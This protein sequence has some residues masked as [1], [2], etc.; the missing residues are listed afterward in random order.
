M[1]SVSSIGLRRTAAAAITGLLTV[2]ISAALPL[3][4]ALADGA[5][6]AVN[7]PAAPANG[8]QTVTFTTAD[9]FAPSPFN[10]TVTI[11]RSATRGDSSPE[12]IDADSTDA[13]GNTVTATFDLTGANP[14]A[15]DVAIEGA[16][17]SPPSPDTVD[18]CQSCLTVQAGTPTI[19]SVQP[20]ATGADFDYP[21]WTI[22]GTNFT[23][24]PYTQCSALP[25]GSKTPNVAI[26]NGNALD[27]DV[28]LS[29]S[30]SD[31]S[32]AT[33]LT[34]PMTIART[35]PGGDRTVVVTNT[36][37]QTASCACLHIAPAMDVTAVSPDHLPVGSTGGTLV[38]TGNNIPS[39]VQATF[40]RQDSGEVGDVAWTS[41]TRNSSTQF[42]LNNVAIAGDTPEDS[43]ENLQL[44]SPS[45]N[46]AH[47]F[48]GV[49]RA[50]GTSP[51]ATPSE[52]AP[53]HV[54]ASP[55]NEKAFVQWTPPASASSD[56]ITGYVVHTAPNG[57]PST[58]APGSA[59]SATVAPLTN[60]QS[61]QFYVVVTYQSSH[62]YTSDLSD[63]ITVSGKPSAPTNVQATAGK[64]NA[65]VSW[66]APAHTNGSAVDSYTV[67]S[68]PD[69]KKTTVTAYGSGAPPTTGV[70]SGLT[71]GTA[72]TFTVTAH[73]G[74]GDS[75]NSDPSNSVTPKGDPTLTLR[76]PRSVARGSTATLRGQLLDT[77]G[78]PVAGASIKLQQRHSGAH[79]YGT[80]KV[81]KTSKHGRWSFDVKPLTTTR[82][83]VRWHGDDAD[84]SVVTA[85]NVKVHETG[86]ITSPKNGAHVSAGEVTVRGRASSAKGFPVSL[87]QRL[88]GKWVTLDRGQVGSRHKVVLHANLAPGQAVLRLQVSGELGTVSGHSRS[89]RVTV[90]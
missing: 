2:G 87:Q 86:R 48:P 78:N 75:A 13:S 70:V 9:T 74:G 88:N 33:A 45:N 81:L 35:D 24:G 50:G 57:D 55:G 38:V 61:Y 77:N 19:A 7:P 72:Y 18:S 65:T 76:A 8:E 37:G 82:Y 5:I 20:N 39:D 84:N 62:T 89:V 85:R 90:S 79:Q 80:L 22:H 34:M 44:T 66:H 30:N 3:G 4:T 67:T 40:I 28:T 69:N 49:F 51:P 58:S 42:T 53:T 60:G 83:K 16:T 52:S 31:D 12:T 56:P 43:I 46:V 27:P 11:T 63:P 6:T 14:G 36:D 64:G 59:S 15:Y 54:T 17:S 1:R 21:Q 32:S 68:S 10:P 71:N 23:N 41:L 29:D 73:N 25:C 47:T 26:F